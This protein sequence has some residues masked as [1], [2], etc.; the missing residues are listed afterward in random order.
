[1]LKDVFFMVVSQVSTRS[2][3]ANLSD[4]GHNIIQLISFHSNIIQ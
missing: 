1:M 4:M 3:F 2:Q